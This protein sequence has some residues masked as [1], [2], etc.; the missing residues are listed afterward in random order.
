MLEP[1]GSHIHGTNGT[2]SGIV[3]MLKNF[4]ETARYVDQGGSKRNGSF[5]IYLSPDHPDIEDWLDLKKNTGDENARARDLFYG[6]W[7]FRSFYATG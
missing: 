5:A 4:N 7:V 3:P 2:S 6:L 1:T